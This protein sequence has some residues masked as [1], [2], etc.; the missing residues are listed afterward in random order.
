MEAADYRECF[1][2]LENHEIDAIL[3]DVMLPEMSGL[4]ILEHLA[5]NPPSPSTIMVTA[6]DVIANAVTALKLGAFDYLTKPEDTNNL[7]KLLGV[8]R[9]AVA[10]GK[11]EKEIDRLNRQLADR[12][13]FENI[14]G[15]SPKMDG[16]YK[17]AGF[18]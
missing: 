16:V 15:D 10:V 6:S 9:N 7:P 18:G 17:H 2:A 12:Y 1:R 4:E 5:A 11:A 8:T 3:L 13:R 14:V